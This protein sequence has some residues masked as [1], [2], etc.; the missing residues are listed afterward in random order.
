MRYSILQ[1]EVKI[2]LTPENLDDLWIV[3][4]IVQNDDLI[5]AKTTRRFRVDNSKD[6][7]KKTVFVKIKLEKKE[8]DFET[9]HVKF[10]GQITDGT[11]I[12][13]VDV[14]SYHTLDIEPGDQVK[15]EKTAFL[16]YERDFLESSKN[17]TLGPKILAIVLDDESATIAEINYSNYNV[18]ARANSKNKG[19]R[20][21]V[22]EDK[23]YFKEIY[24]TLK[25]QKYDLLVCAGPGFEKEKVLLYLK[26][27]G[28]KSKN[29]IV[30]LNGV[31]TNGLLELIKSKALSNV[32]QDF[33]ISQDIEKM[34]FVLHKI[35]K[36]KSN[37]VYG[38]KD[39]ENILENQITAISELIVSTDYF[40][41]NFL[42]IKPYFL[43]LTGQGARIHLIDSKNDAG[44]I[45]E[46]L[47]SLILVLHYSI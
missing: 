41:K 32:L 24:D 47:G 42:K 44:K 17:S 16:G 22:D 45:L 13:F 1:K 26:E 34:N 21:A 23:T 38:E 35:T 12:E 14:G 19:K 8:L 27:K 43:K 28:L 10:T 29:T 39:I 46:G 25:N 3:Y 40:N 31:G 4:N 37:I 36:D 5:S 20:Y 18:I 11:P 6:S 2:I 9:G 33:K 30:G 15:I 7:E